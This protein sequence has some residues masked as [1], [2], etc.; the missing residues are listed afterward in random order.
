VTSIE[1]LFSAD[2][3]TVISAVAVSLNYPR[4]KPAPAGKLR[5][6]K[7]KSD[8]EKSKAVGQH[9]PRLEH[10]GLAHERQLFEL[11]HAAGLFCA[12]QVAFTGVHA[13]DLAGGGDLK[14]FVRA[15]VRLQLHFRF[16]SVSRHSL[17]LLLSGRAS[18]LMLL[19]VNQ[20]QPNLFLAS[21]K[22]LR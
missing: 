13:L 6:Y 12:E 2:A 4:S 15:A 3:G 5:H 9:L 19:E 1:K 14:A 20:P 21:R 11:A 22:I 16:R 8:T 10:I 7:E 17:K 18:P